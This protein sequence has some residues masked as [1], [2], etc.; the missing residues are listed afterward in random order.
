M[1]GDEENEIQHVRAY[2]ILSLLNLLES[3]IQVHRSTFIIITI[4]FLYKIMQ[5]VS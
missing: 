2:C 5:L 1:L 3:N 4:L